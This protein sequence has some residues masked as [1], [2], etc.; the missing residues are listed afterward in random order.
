MQLIEDMVL[1]HV[2]DMSP[3]VVRRANDA[4][5]FA[6]TKITMGGAFHTGI[7]VFGQEQSFGYPTGMYPSVPRAERN[8]VYR[9]SIYLGRTSLTK[10][11]VSTLLQ[12]MRSSWQPSEYHTIDRN[13]NDFC[14]EFAAHLGVGQF[15]GWVD[16]LGR[17]AKG[18]A[19]AYR[20]ASAG[21]TEVRSAVERL[22][23]QCHP[24]HYV[25]NELEKC[26]RPVVEC[27]KNDVEEI[28]DLVS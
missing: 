5:S 14:A 2:Y 6:L 22:A 25:A 26:R 4:L 28:S 19:A 18:T 24:G 27:L 15:P 20:G 23:E 8:H 17:F 9:C 16:R 3:G 12:E 10:S 7:E 13:C 1:L 21:A 11:E